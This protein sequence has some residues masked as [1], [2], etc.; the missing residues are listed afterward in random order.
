M[1]GYE[2]GAARVEAWAEDAK[3]LAGSNSGPTYAMCAIAFAIVHA[4]DTIAVELKALAPKSPYR[5]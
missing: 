2:T 4:A 5:D 1:T 3:G